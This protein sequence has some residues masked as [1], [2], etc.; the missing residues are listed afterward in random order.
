MIAGLIVFTN[1]ISRAANYAYIMASV[2]MGFM[3]Y[4]LLSVNLI[5]LIHLFVDANAQYFGFAAIILAS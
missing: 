4:L 3:L 5:D 1:A 2:L